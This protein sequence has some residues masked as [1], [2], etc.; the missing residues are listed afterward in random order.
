MGTCAKW[1]QGQSRDFRPLKERESGLKCV[2]RWVSCVCRWM[3]HSMMELSVRAAVRV[4]L[5]CVAVRQQCLES[6]RGPWSS[7]VA[8]VDSTWWLLDATWQPMISTAWVWWQVSVQSLARGAVMSLAAM[9]PTQSPMS[10]PPPDHRRSVLWRT[11][12]QD[13]RRWHTSPPVRNS[14]RLF[15]GLYCWA[16]FG[17]NL[18]CYACRVLSP[19]IGIHTTRHRAH[20]VKTWRHPQNRKYITYCDAATGWPRHSHSLR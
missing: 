15:A 3:S 16:K 13:N 4:D 2:L 14:P 20:Y 19:L 8:A 7:A 12:H 11:H 1:I 18:D 5:W 10:S 17:L 6:H 9:S